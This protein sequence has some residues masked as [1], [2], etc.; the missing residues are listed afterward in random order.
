[1]SVSHAPTSPVSSEDT[2]VGLA[3]VAELYALFSQVVDPRRPRGVRHHIAG[4][5]TVMVFAVLAGARN[6]RE[7]GDRAVD[8]PP[9]LLE[10]AGTR[11]DPRTGALVPPSGST[12][13]RVTEDIDVDAADLLV[14]QWIA[15]RARR[16]DGADDDVVV[17]AGRWGLAMD[18]KTVRRSGAGNPDGNVKLFS[19]M[20]HDEAVV[21]AQL[22][23]PDTTTEVTQV[24]Q[25]LDPVDLTK[26]VVTGDAAHTL[27]RTAAYIRCRGGDYV[28]TLKAN[29]PSLLDSV[30]AKLF[31][32]TDL[33][34]HLDIDTS[35]GRTVH[36]QIWATDA[37][38]I[39]FPGAAQVFRI[40][41]D[42]FDPSGQRIS[43]EIVHG[44]A[45]LAEASAQALARWVRQHWG[46]ENKIH[47]SP[48]PERAASTSTTTVTCCR[49]GSLF[50]RYQRVLFNGWSGSS[51]V[52][53]CGHASGRDADLDGARRRLPHGAGGRGVVG[54]ASASVV[55]EHGARLRDGVGAVV[56]VSGAAR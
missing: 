35:R 1:V 55:A 36:R 12:L 20:L 34:H 9:S 11:R 33:A 32:T 28:L 16:V 24:E 45:S 18:G 56:D 52:Q 31:A 15:E 5:L 23:V 54:G 2:G 21:I 38:G 22:R 43:K 14:C 25:L 42:V 30:I 7:A 48:G 13:R 44:I 53:P 29:Q 4:V 27:P 19:A 10:A 26:A 17:A 50:R 47:L 39:D 8:L 40:R 3:D 6:F 51:G 49:Y 46:I 41:R 37:A